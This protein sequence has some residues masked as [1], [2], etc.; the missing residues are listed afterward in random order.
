MLVHAAV[1]AVA[2]SMPAKGPHGWATSHT[3]SIGG[4]GVSTPLAH[5]PSTAIPTSWVWSAP[6]TGSVAGLEDD[7]ARVDGLE[8]RAG[9]QLEVAEG[10]VVPPGIVLRR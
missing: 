5:F 7:R 9:D 4:V 6:G 3:W 8:G 10:V 2:P 1:A